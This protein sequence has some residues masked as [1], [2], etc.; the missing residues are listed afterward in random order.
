MTEIDD[1]EVQILEAFKNVEYPMKHCISRSSE[2][3]EARLLTGQ[4]G[5][6]KH[7]SDFSYEEL[8]SAPNGLGSSL[9]FLSDEA[10]HHFMPG[11][12]IAEMRKQLDHQSISFFMLRGLT[13][14]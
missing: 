3:D 11:Y 2:G 7:W 9:S 5:D 8:D 4:F 14:K 13:N 10:L 12:M 1:C 6:A